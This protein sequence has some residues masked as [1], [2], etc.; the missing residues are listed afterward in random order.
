MKLSRLAQ[1]YDRIQAAGSEPKRVQILA[2][3]FSKADAKTLEALA[4]FT[5]SEVVDPRLS[6]KLGI[7]PG[8]IR[9]ALAEASHK[10]E[11]EIDDEVKR[12][13][14]MSE[15][16]AEFARG[17]DHLTVDDMWERVNRT[18]KRDEDRMN[19][20]EH[21]FENTTAGGAKAA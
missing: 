20:V 5:V 19:L 1:T 8:T 6:D 10:G 18:V 16:V 12:T 3:L 14:D 11:A 17:R 13:G 15:I 9:A 21:V 4:H 2:E 7:G